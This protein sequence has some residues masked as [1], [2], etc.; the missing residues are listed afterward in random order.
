MHNLL[1]IRPRTQTDQTDF[2]GPARFLWGEIQKSFCTGEQVAVGPETGAETHQTFDADAIAGD[3][4]FNS[5]ALPI[6]ISDGT[7]FRP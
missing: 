6:P 1:W 5:A 2:N 7:E 4:R 3:F